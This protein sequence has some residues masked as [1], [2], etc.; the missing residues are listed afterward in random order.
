[1]FRNWLFNKDHIMFFDRFCSEIGFSTKAIESIDLEGFVPGLQEDTWNGSCSQAQVPSQ[2][3][4][5]G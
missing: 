2:E 4:K 1:M 5:V 3:A